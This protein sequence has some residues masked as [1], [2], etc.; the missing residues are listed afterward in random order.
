LHK[1]QYLASRGNICPYCLESN[2]EAL[3]SPCV[4]EGIATE[5]MHCID[6]NR[7]W[8]GIYK[9]VGVEESAI[10]EEEP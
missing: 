10:P 8:T 6:C 7:Y 4:V 5:E 2:I 1:K 3:E 9:L